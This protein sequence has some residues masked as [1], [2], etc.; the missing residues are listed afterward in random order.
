M[1]NFLLCLF[2]Y[3]FT[4]GYRI[5]SPSKTNNQ[6]SP[7]PQ[8]LKSPHNSFFIVAHPDDIELFMG[9]EARHQILEQ[10]ENKKIFIVLS[11]GDANRKNRKKIFREITWWKAREQAHTL[12][13]SYWNKNRNLAH[14]SEITVNHRKMTKITLGAS[15]ILYNFRLTDADK[16]TSLNDLIH[17]NSQ[18]IYDLAHHQAYRKQDIQTSLL[19]L[20]EYE[21]IGAQSAAFY[22]MDE[23]Y[24]RNPGDHKDHKA[25]SEIFKEIYTQISVQ[26]KSLHGYLTY[27]I[28]EKVINLE[29]EDKHVSFETWRIIAD[30]LERNGY[31]RNDDPHHMQ[32]VGKEYKSYEIKTLD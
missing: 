24:D 11:A 23:S 21:N 18:E 7:E 32:W 27:F 19:E 12:A 14:E 26:D 29:G 10:P 6:Q 25:T 15:I 1:K 2:R 28:Q 22:I 8:S 3:I 13:I 17:Q 30:E 4:L 9:R 31:K 20:I 16:T 5:S